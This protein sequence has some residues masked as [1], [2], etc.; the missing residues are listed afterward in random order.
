MIRFINKLTGGDMWVA[1]SRRDEYIRAGHKP[2]LAVEPADEPVREETQ[3][4]TE[5][6]KPVRKTTRKK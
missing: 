6:K 3:E 4:E 1:D 2:A 5:V